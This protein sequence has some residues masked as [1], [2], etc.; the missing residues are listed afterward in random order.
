MTRRRR[1]RRQH[2]SNVT[3]LFLPLPVRPQLAWPVPPLCAAALYWRPGGTSVMD[4]GRRERQLRALDGQ[5]LALI[6]AG[7]RIIRG[8]A[9]PHMPCWCDSRSWHVSSQSQCSA[10]REGGE[11]RWKE[12]QRVLIGPWA[13]GYSRL[14]SPDSDWQCRDARLA[15]HLE[16]LKSIGCTK[17]QPEGLLY[18]CFSCSGPM[19]V[20]IKLFDHPPEGRQDN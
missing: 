11:G 10:G 9:W 3:V 19:Q 17:I 4:W 20:Q 2:T 15:Y 5:L 1:R 8:E 16:S 12:R 13:E 6:A 7:Q 14:S 18:A